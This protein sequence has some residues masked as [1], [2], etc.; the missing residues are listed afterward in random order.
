MRVL[1]FLIVPLVL[2]SCSNQQTERTPVNE[3]A[4]FE[5]GSA[6]MVTANGSKPG[7]YEVT[8]SDGTVSRTVLH[9][10]GTYTDTAADGSVVA[11]GTW[12]VTDNKT[13]FAPS[14]EGAEAMCFTETAPS[15]DGSFT[16]TPE[17]GEPV[18]VR[19]LASE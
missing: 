7:T 1:A 14:T 3:P 9:A 5:S 10:D 18:T 6:S 15:D 4:A 19:P 8:G 12:T 17:E 13:C 2:A 16:A 11:E